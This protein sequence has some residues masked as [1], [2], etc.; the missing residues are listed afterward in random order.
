M[1]VDD[2]PTWRAF[3]IEHISRVGLTAIDVA[4]DGVQAVYKARTPQLG[5]I[6]MD[7]KLPHLDGIQAAARIL[8]LAPAVKIVFVSG[9]EDP[10][11]V[12]TALNAGGFDYVVKSRAGRDLIPAIKRALGGPAM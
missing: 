10:E 6:L 3:V 5:L 12:C 9:I 8:E 2:N 4:Y 1:V 11:V 7:V